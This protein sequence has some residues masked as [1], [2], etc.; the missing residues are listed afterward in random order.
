[1]TLTGLL[2]RNI[3][4]KY[5]TVCEYNNNAMLTAA[6]VKHI[7]IKKHCRDVFAAFGWKLILQLIAFKYIYHEHYEGNVQFTHSAEYAVQSF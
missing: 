1:M 2:E 6:A 5:P 4:I 7:I 3:D